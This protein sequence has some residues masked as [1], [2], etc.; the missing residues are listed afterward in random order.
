MIGTNDNSSQNSGTRLRKK[1]TNAGATA[2]SSSFILS[3]TRGVANPVTDPGILDQQKIFAEALRQTN[4]IATLGSRDAGQAATS[5]GNGTG[6]PNGLKPITCK[7]MVTN[8]KS[9]KSLI[10]GVNPCGKTAEVVAVH[11]YKVLHAGGDAQI[12]NPP[13]KIAENVGDIR[14]SPDQASKKD[15]IFRFRTNDGMLI[16]KQNGQVKTGS[17]AY[18]SKKLVEMT[19][20]PGYGKIGYVDARFVNEDGTPRIAK[21][22]FTKHQAL[23]L[24]KAKVRLRGIRELDSRSKQLHEDLQSYTTDELDPVTRSKL[25]Q[26]RDDIARAYQWKG[27]TTRMAGGMGLAAASAAVVSLITQAASDGEI[28]GAEIGEAAIQGGLFGAGGV[29]ADAG[30]Y[31]ICM[32]QNI[33]PESAKII[34]QQGVGV[35]FCLLAIGMDIQSEVEAVQNGEIS[36][37]DAMAGGSLKIALDLLPLVLSPLGLAGVPILVGAQLGGRWVITK[38][39]EADRNIRL[40][41]HKNIEKAESLAIRLDH[42]DKM[43]DVIKSECEETDRIFEAAMS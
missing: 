41:F 29:L 12:T 19:K 32:T 30:I 8:G 24:Q 3:S 16:T 35:G 1:E 25:M 9:L 27:V 2:A 37:A 22:A 36:R 11:D 10:G 38:V 15:L 14:L 33:P 5:I 42:I 43:A 13:L 18:I 4:P 21:D 34:A 6:L 40:E 39:R 20:S 26:F 23:K 17:G 7:Q 31:H 28:N